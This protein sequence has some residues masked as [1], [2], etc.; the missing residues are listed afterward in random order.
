ML[1]R[2]CKADICVNGADLR[3]WDKQMTSSWY[4]CTH[5]GRPCDTIEKSITNKDDTNERI[6]GSGA[7]CTG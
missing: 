5:C 7:L 6:Y 2:C 4:E 1:S 3:W